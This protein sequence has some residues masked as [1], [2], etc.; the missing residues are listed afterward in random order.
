MK[1]IQTT[2]DCYV[3]LN[4]YMASLNYDNG[5]VNSFVSMLEFIDARLAVVPDEVRI[6][7]FIIIDELEEYNESI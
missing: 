4:D 5:Q 3:I 7:Y 6:A 2:Q 1:T